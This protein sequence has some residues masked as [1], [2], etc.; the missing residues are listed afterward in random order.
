MASVQR[1][2]EAVR[3]AGV[4]AAY[5]FGSHARGTA[6]RESDVDVAVLLDRGRFPERGG[7][8]REALRLCTELIA[9][10]HSNQVD[11]VLL[12]DVA[13]EFAAGIVSRGRRLYCTDVE[14]DRAFVRTALLRHADI[15]PFL[16][17]ARRVKLRALAR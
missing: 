15:R 1:Y 17:R 5:L 4:V 8:G 13:P 14:A 16:D 6:H 3:P 11:V 2:L 10:T 9:A 7:R 12:N